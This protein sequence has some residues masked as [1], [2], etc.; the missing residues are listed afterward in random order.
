MN[1]YKMYINK[2][3]CWYKKQRN[4]LLC[5]LVLDQICHISLAN[6]VDPDQAAVTR[7]A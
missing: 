7:V 6:R 3:S 5:L 1:N 2:L 4:Y